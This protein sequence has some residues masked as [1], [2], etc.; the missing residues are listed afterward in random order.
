MLLRL[1][2]KE[3]LIYKLKEKDIINLQES[4]SKNS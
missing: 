4:G 3:N 1:E 2:D